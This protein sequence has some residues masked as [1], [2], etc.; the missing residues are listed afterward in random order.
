MKAISIREP[1]AGMIRDG[2]KTIETRTWKTKHRGSLLLCACSK[3]ASSIS[4]MGFAVANLVECRDM[5]VEDEQLAC[6][7]FNPSAKAWILEDVK[8][9]K[10][11]HVRGRLG[12]FDV[13]YRLDDV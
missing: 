10:P 3:P 12:I 11:F 5:G 1:W 9:I 6:C 13:D 2:R 8:R 7:K 4:G